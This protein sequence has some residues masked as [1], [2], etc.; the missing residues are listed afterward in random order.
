MATETDKAVFLTTSINDF[1]YQYSYD[2]SSSNWSRV[3]DG[4]EDFSGPYAGVCAAGDIRDDGNGSFGDW[5][6]QQGYIDFVVDYDEI[7]RGSTIISCAIEVDLDAL[8][9]SGGTFRVE[10]YKYNFGNSVGN[11]DWRNDTELQALADTGQRVGWENSANLST[12]GG[13]ETIPD[14]DGDAAGLLQETIDA[15][16]SYFRLVMSTNKH[17]TSSQ[18]GTD[19]VARLAQV[20][21]NNQ[22]RLRVTFE[23]PELSLGV[24]L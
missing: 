17:R 3:V 18:L 1:A 5:R 13:W 10:F 6:I 11:G 22:I 24:A 14:K 20:F 19:G 8:N 16:Q 2:V 12:G 15:G 7:P 23:S 4:L 9:E 21:T